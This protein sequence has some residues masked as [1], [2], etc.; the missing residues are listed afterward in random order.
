M[1]SFSIRI[2]TMLITALAVFA[3]VLAVPGKDSK[4]YAG[5][6]TVTLK[7]VVYTNDSTTASCEFHFYSSD[8]IT[9]IDPM[10]GSTQGG[11]DFDLDTQDPTN[12]PTGWSLSARSGECVLIA[13]PLHF[14]TNSGEKPAVGS[15]IF[16]GVA[17]STDNGE[18]EDQLQVTVPP[19][20]EST[21]VV[22]SGYAFKSSLKAAKITLKESMTKYKYTGMQIKPKVS[23]FYP[24]NNSKNSAKG[25]A[26][27]TPNETE[28]VEGTDYELSYA[29]N[30]EIGTATV[31]ATGIGNYED[32]ISTTFTI[33]PA[34]AGNFSISSISNQNYTGKAIKPTPTVSYQ[35][36]TL[37]KDT[38]YTLS[39]S[40]NK[41]PGKATVTVTG[42]G[43]Y[44]GSTQKTFK[45]IGKMSKASV[46]KIADQGYTKKAV[47][48]VP[49]VKF[50]GVTLKNKTDFT[51]SYK[52]NVKK[53]TA[54]VTIKGKGYYTGSKNATFRIRKR[55]RITYDAKITLG[56][57]NKDGAATYSG[58][59]I[60]PTVKSVKLDGTTLKEGTDYTVSYE[61]N[62]DASDRYP[63]PTVIVTGKNLYYGSKKA[64][65]VINKV[66]WNLKVSDIETNY[67]TTKETITLMKNKDLK[68]MYSCLSIDSYTLATS[69]R[70]TKTYYS[71]N[72]RI[73]WPKKKSSGNL[74]ITIPAAFIGKI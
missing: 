58:K 55:V 49:T 22:A 17:I 42:K 30:I 2:F 32:S 15:T 71:Y 29:N 13:N 31:T 34:V 66:K 1:K 65:F 43:H 27:Y 35:G 60:K 7:K 52:N 72:D 57:L 18:A 26:K 39:Y 23:I 38:D 62:V 61:N 73:K 54:T 67:S 37:T 16:V 63:M 4:V 59:A 28:L 11:Y 24:R 9:Y 41:L 48:P 64:Y 8:T 21:T 40:N 56:G 70:G 68:E 53:G 46:D 14:T 45:I 3:I 50:A 44:T 5:G 19:V 6:A 12:L 25:G 51:L 69:S 33:E 36:T 47:T 20:G 74:T 10:I